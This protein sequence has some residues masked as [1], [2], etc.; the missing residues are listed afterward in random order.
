[1]KALT[2]FAALWTPALVLSLTIAPTATLAA[3]SHGQR[4]ADFASL[5][6]QSATFRDE[7]MPPVSTEFLLGSNAK[8]YKITS[9]DLDLVVMD[10]YFDAMFQKLSPA[11][12][13]HLAYACC[14]GWKNQKCR[15]AKAA[16]P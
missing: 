15:Q 6:W 10:V 7:K 8:K 1:M 2:R 14:M 11:K 5:Y 9:N 16:T 3:R 13:G 4:C 12:V